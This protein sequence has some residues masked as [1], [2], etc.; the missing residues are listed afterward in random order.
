[1]LTHLLRT[2]LALTSLLIRKIPGIKLTGG[3]TFTQNQTHLFSGTIFDNIISKTILWNIWGIT[4]M[5]L[6]AYTPDNDYSDISY[7]YRYV[8]CFI[9][10][11]IMIYIGS[12]QNIKGAGL[13]K[14]F[15]L[16]FD[17]GQWPFAL[18]FIFHDCVVNPFALPWILN[19]VQSQN[20]K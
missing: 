11:L 7:S 4:N 8:L 17:N 13:L 10:R 2:P 20:E 16:D 14:N 5:F 18:L 3:G 15:G 6:A 9:Y 12:K 19:K 1:M